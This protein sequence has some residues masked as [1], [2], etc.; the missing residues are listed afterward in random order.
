MNL[1]DAVEPFHTRTTTIV[2]TRSQIGLAHPVDRTG[3]SCGESDSPRRRSD[4][5][6]G[7]ERSAR[8]CPHSDSQSSPSQSSPVTRESCPFSRLVD[9]SRQSVTRKNGRCAEIQCR[10]ERVGVIQGGSRVRREVAFG[11]GCQPSPGMRS[12]RS[13]GPAQ[14]GYSRVKRGRR[15]SRNSSESGHDGLELQQAQRA[16][17]RDGQSVV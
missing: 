17:R 7:G 9:R 4:R 1:R 13:S 6:P 12:T 14:F 8:R 11:R 15:C 16:G 10:A 2:M 3:R 5:R